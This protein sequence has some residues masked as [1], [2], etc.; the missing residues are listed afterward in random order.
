VKRFIWPAAALTVILLMIFLQA[1]ASQDPASGWEETFFKANQ[2][3]KERR[4]KAAIDGYE[5]ITR[6]GPANGHIYYN[7][8]NAYFKED[9]LGRTILNY[10]RALF[11]MPRDAD[12]NYNLR[13]ARDQIKDDIPVSKSLMSTTLFWLDSLRPGEIF[14]AFA[15]LNVMFSLTLMLRLFYRSDGIYYL[16]IILLIFWLITGGSLGLKW[17]QIN[18]GT[19][20]VILDKEVSALAGPDSKDTVLFKLHEGAI[21][22]QERSEDGWFLINLPDEKR[23]WVKAGSVESINRDQ[24]LNTRNVIKREIDDG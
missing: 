12:L 16:I 19:R 9:Q 23:G 18:T 20:V 14:W 17:Y 11:L 24:V 1:S 21:V 8:G 15:I 22:N 4:F 7:L 5:Q 6:S 3:Y 2:A 13:Y 10:E